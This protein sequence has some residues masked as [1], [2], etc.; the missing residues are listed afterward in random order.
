MNMFKLTTSTDF[1]VANF[2]QT[3]LTLLLLTLNKHY[4]LISCFHVNNNHVT[5]KP[6]R[7]YCV[8]LISKCTSW[9]TVISDLKNK[10]KM[11]YE[12]GFGGYTN[13][14]ET[15]VLVTKTTGQIQQI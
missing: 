9:E 12:K 11:C 8:F 3:L 7:Y 10:F 15:N 14:F 1:I 2:E 13:D 4:S 6:F 5:N